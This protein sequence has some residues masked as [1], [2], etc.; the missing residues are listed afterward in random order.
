M[1]TFIYVNSIDSLFLLIFWHFVSFQSNAT[2]NTPLQYCRKIGSFRAQ[3]EEVAHSWPGRFLTFP[4]TQKHK[5]NFIQCLA[6]LNSQRGSTFV[7]DFS[8]WLQLRILKVRYS[9]KRFPSVDYSRTRFLRLVVDVKLS[10]CSLIPW[11]DSK[12]ILQYLKD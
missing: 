11:F 6:L 12:R 9:S 7:L 3:L 10:L 2:C 5:E 8:R 4:F 1:S